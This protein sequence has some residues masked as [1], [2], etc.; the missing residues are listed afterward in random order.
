M[1]IV[2]AFRFD[3]FPPFLLR[4]PSCLDRSKSPG[5]LGYSRTAFSFEFFSFFP[6]DV[7]AQ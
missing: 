1:I 5:N 3:L 7:T 6:F 4:I 2:F